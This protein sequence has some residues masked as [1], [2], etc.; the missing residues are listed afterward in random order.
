MRSG[1]E[2]TV[3]PGE[4]LARR[5]PQRPAEG[6]PPLPIRLSATGLRRALAVSQRSVVTE[7]CFLETF[8]SRP[9][10]QG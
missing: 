5:N 3:G 1:V 8:A 4:G 6:P 7:L 10:L 2:S 9:R